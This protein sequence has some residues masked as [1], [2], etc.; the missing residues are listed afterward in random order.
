MTRLLGMLLVL[1]VDGVGSTAGLQR[2]AANINRHSPGE[3]VGVSFEKNQPITGAAVAHLGE[4]SK[5]RY[6]SL[7]DSQAETQ[8]T[9]SGGK[10][11]RSKP[12]PGDRPQQPIPKR[13]A[14]A[15]A[16]YKPETVQEIHLQ[17]RDRDLARMHAALPDRIYVPAAFRWG[18]QTIENVGV[19]YKGN[20]SSRSDQRHKRSFL[21]KFNEFSKGG[22]FLGLRRVSFDNGVQFGSLFS[23]PLITAVLR[24][25]GITAP[26]C[27]FVRLFVNRK[28]Q[29]V[30]TNV[31]RIDKVFLKKHF[32]D[33]SG[34]LYKV[35]EGGPGSDLAPLP[36]RPANRI[37]HGFEP[38]SK[39]ARFDARDVLALISRI[40]ETPTEKFSDVMQANMNMDALLKTMAVMLFA[41]AFDQLTG[42]NPH[43]YYLYRD[44][45]DDRWHYLPWDLDVGFA[46]N[47]FRRVPVIDGWNAAW[48][49]PGGPPRPLIERIVDDPGLLAR[50][51]QLAD[52]ILED[53]F[54]PNIL[55]PRI[56][57]LY[58]QIEADLARDPFPHRR[59]T[60][61]ED[62]GFDT[63]VTSIKGFVR[64]R[65]KIAR[66]QLDA[67]GSRPPIARRRPRREQEPQPGK[68]SLDA[69]SGL[70]VLE[71][72]ASKVTLRWTDNAEGEA[73][74]IVQ[75][76]G[77]EQGPKFR[78]H[79]GKPGAEISTAA[80]IRVTAGKTYRY[81]VYAVRPA[82][83]GQQGTGLSNTITVR[84][85][86]K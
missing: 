7:G 53:H 62:R 18:D 15:D 47:A 36:P 26:R 80:D 48:P 51:R 66:A 30:F 35:D 17:V 67:P 70:R 24:D 44:P 52:S 14:N 32:R 20:S 3:V 54:H 60:N 4:L 49:I 37:R 78:N 56:D 31:E 9:V 81:R 57:A 63:I 34:A 12:V 79:I 41:G 45:G 84:V 76:A 72:T 43:N 33:G 39:A 2:T 16:F 71:I 6:L 58:A 73:G 46:D 13:A 29:G 19:R 85:P 27:N 64:R 22:T 59:V 69:P 65:Y 10:K 68:P 74:H 11:I 50:Y 38:K 42:W 83:D 40:N 25:L 86:D 77:G 21:I 82:P 1:V 5:R 61:P 23:E 55:L 8:T 28:F 75:R